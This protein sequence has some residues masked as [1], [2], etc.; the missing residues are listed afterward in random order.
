MM[1]QNFK[2]ILK[3]PLQ[4][5]FADILKCPLQGLFADI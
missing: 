1:L 2:D 5:L 4:G 3:C